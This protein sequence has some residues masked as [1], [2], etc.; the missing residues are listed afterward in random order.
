MY[1]IY[2]HVLYIYMYTYTYLHVG[3]SH[4]PI[5]QLSGAVGESQQWRLRRFGDSERRVFGIFQGKCTSSMRET[6]I[7]NS[8]YCTWHR[9]PAKQKKDFLPIDH[10]GDLEH[11]VLEQW[12]FCYLF[13]QVSLRFT[14]LKFWSPFTPG[15]YGR[16]QRA[17]KGAGGL[18]GGHASSSRDG[19][20]SANA[21]KMIKISNH[22]H[23]LTWVQLWCI[24][25]TMY[26]VFFF[27]DQLSP[28]ISN[29]AIIWIKVVCSSVSWWLKSR[30]SVIYP[31][32]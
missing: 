8:P 14:V 26:I 11:R 2:T 22:K 19:T 10:I 7:S 29:L 32:F 3:S 24:V 27:R 5:S 28:K 20:L 16:S 1:F 12:L 31:I 17:G 25:Y 15:L 9:C 23:W 6:H 18:A 21:M 13:V 4:S 30:T